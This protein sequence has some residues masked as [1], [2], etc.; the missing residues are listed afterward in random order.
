MRSTP[1]DRLTGSL[2]VWSATAVVVGTIIGAG[3]Y[4][5][6]ATVASQSGSVWM[7][8][9]LWG[10]GGLI[11]I[12]GALSL[13][14]LGAMFPRAGGIYVFMKETYGP[15]AAFL[16]G[17]GMLVVNPAAYAA[18]AVIFA[19]AVATIAPM[20]Q[21]GIRYVAAGMIL[22]L[23]LINYRS[24]R[25]GAAVQN[26]STAAKVAVL[27]GLSMLGLIVGGTADGAGTTER[28]ALGA[29]SFGAGLIA[30]VFAYDGWQWLPQLAAEVK[31]PTRTIPRAMGGGVL[32]IVVVY[33]LVNA[34]NVRVLGMEGV[35]SSTLV[36]GDVAT[37]LLGVAGASV[38]A[39]LIA[40]STFSSNNGGFMTDPRVFF[41]MADD[42]LFFR[43]VA[44]VH[45]RFGTPHVAIILTGGVAMIYVFVST[46]E[47][48]AATLILG[49]WPFLAL[50]AWSVI[51]LRRGRP[52]MA[53]PFRVPLYPLLPA[54]F[55]AACAFLFADSLLNAPAMTLINFAILGAGIPVF[56]VWRTVRL[57]AA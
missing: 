11:A 6:P 2:G 7:L 48:M 21:S 13:A 51:R 39:A 56:L 43:S 30:V 3:I 37:H 10:L 29:G 17:W 36:T 45:S 46:F 40:L 54:F 22:V 31:E 35:A 57:R 49:M 15:M 50:S 32:L 27:V 14:E 5:V 12:A 33:F 52:E 9:T 24:V 55:L 47:R 8:F 4:R 16:F 38:V 23:V 44:S 34:A 18:V 42:G 20:A 53:R 1:S 28:V 25:F 41:A 19:E 26:A